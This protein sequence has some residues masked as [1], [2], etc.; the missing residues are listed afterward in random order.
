MEKSEKLLFDLLGLAS[1]CGF[2]F[3]GYNLYKLYRKPKEG[4][5]T[6]SAD[7]VK[8]TSFVTNGTGINQTQYL[9]DNLS[10]QSNADVTISPSI[11][12]FNRELGNKPKKL[13]KLEFRNV[14]NI[15]TNQQEAPFQMSCNDASGQASS[16]PYTPMVA[17]NQFQAGMT[18][19]DFG[20]K[21]LDGS[22][23]MAYTMYPNSKVMIVVHYIDMPLSAL[24]SNNQ[25]VESK[26]TENK[27]TETKP[28]SENEAK[29]V[30]TEKKVEQNNTPS[31]NTTA[32]E[33]QPIN[34]YLGLAI[35][36]GVGIICYKLITQKT[37]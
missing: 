35:A 11:G 4:G 16:T 10:N 37:A 29:V 15:A 20:D 18:S 1:V 19:V 12:F 24:L 33:K 28:A 7:G 21:I 6:S 31:N 5:E 25:T 34:T 22:C 9:F 30:V 17:I 26:V 3:A 8:T 36:A 27:V 13:I 32:K 2:V 14:G 23:Y